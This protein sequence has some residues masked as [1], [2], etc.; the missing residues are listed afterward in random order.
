MV[1]SLLLALLL[2]TLAGAIPRW[3]YSRSWGYYPAAGIAVML[4]G[5]LL[6]RWLNVF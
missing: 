6:L 2:I 1:L 3:P 5:V 4:A